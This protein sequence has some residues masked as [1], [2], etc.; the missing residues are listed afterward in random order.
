MARFLNV[1]ALL[2][3]VSAAALILLA[4]CGE[5]ESRGAEGFEEA[6][7]YGFSNQYQ[8]IGRINGRASNI[9]FI[10]PIIDAG[11]PGTRQP[12]PPGAVPFVAALPVTRGNNA[13]Q[14]DPDNN[15]AII[16]RYPSTQSVCEAQSARVTFREEG[17]TWVGSDLDV[18]IA[19]C[20]RTR[21]GGA[22]VIGTIS[23][24]VAPSDGPASGVLNFEADF[25]VDVVYPTAQ[26][27]SRG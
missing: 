26:E 14:P 9:P 17:G 24:R 2:H 13:G 23:G 1:K 12:P 25:E 7:E 20:E 22:D 10:Y 15:V 6:R 4:A 21:Y 11:M 5:D 27:R 18:T 19:S 8:V 16:V 3:L